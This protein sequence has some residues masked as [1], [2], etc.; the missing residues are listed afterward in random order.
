MTQR[1]RKGRFHKRPLS[2]YYMREAMPLVLCS[3]CLSVVLENSKE[4]RD[5][6]AQ[7]VE[8]YRLP[9]IEAA[10]RKLRCEL[11]P[12]EVM[13]MWKENVE[14]LRIRQPEN[15]A[16]PRVLLPDG[17]FFARLNNKA[18]AYS[19]AF[20][21]WFNLER[22]EILSPDFRHWCELINELIR[23]GF[24]KKS[25]QDKGVYKVTAEGSQ[26]LFFAIHMRAFAEHKRVG[27]VNHGEMKAFRIGR[28][29]YD[30]T[31]L[32]AV[33]PTTRRHRLWTKSYRQAG[34]GQQHDHIIKRGAGWWYQSR[35]VYSNPE[36]FW[37]NKWSPEQDLWDWSNLGRAI[38]PYDDALGYARGE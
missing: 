33:R 30:L 29:T 31:T 23:V 5:I 8:S 35:V 1:R 16:E 19:Y 34:Y 26:F 22:E 13:A 7:I 9:E 21:K 4:A 11:P 10:F 25:D 24:N 27:V 14:D 3:A 12:G 18:S 2:R 28:T 17:D 37:K 38:K 15:K 6:Y 32:L 20:D 36:E